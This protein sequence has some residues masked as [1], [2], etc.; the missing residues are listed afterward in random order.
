MKNFIQL[1]APT[2]KRKDISQ[3]TGRTQASIR[4]VKTLFL[5]ASMI[6]IASCGGG[7][8]GNTTPP[9]ASPTSTDFGGKIIG[10]IARK[11]VAGTWGYTAADGHN[12]AI[13]GTAKGVLV[14][15]LIDPNNPR[16]VD[17]VDGPTDTHA[18]GIYWREMRVYGTHAY[19]VSEHT[20]VRGGIMILDLSALPRSVRYVT[21]VVPRDRQLAAHTVDIDTARGLLYLQR[22]SNT[23]GSPDFVA[24]RDQQSFEGN[25]WVSGVK[26]PSEPVGGANRGSIEIWDI[27]TDPENPI[28]VSTF[29]G[30]KSVHDMT[31]VGKYCYVAEGNAHSYSIWNVEDPKLPVLQVRWEVEAGHFS[32]N[33][34]PSADG[35]L[36]VTTEEIPVGLPAKVWKLNGALAPTLLSSF[37]SGT[38]TPHNVIME[39]NLAYLSHYSEGAMVVDLT[40]PAVPRAIVHVDTNSDDGPALGGCWGVYKFPGQNLMICSDIENGFNLIRITGT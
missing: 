19:I 26:K 1:F 9:A 8:G 20:N 14:L 6:T 33:I 34:W 13:M 4:I 25:Q 37:K 30:G 31:A 23:P 32:H 16:V 35:S 28:Y 11:G 3:E 39:G 38:G 12:Y 5:A 36:V 24:P 17:E 18:P 15:D 27:K 10:K 21:S 29:N 7:S 2:K 22:E 40:N